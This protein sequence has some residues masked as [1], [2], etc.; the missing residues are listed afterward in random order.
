MGRKQERL[1]IRIDDDT[2]DKLVF[3]ERKSNLN[4]SELLRLMIVDQYFNY[5]RF[6]KKFGKCVDNDHLKS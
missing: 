5:E 2:L 6:M 3:L 1:H 4:R